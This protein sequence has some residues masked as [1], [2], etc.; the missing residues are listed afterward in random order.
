MYSIAWV[1]V[2]LLLIGIVVGIACVFTLLR[3]WFG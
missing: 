1:N 2:T 3:R